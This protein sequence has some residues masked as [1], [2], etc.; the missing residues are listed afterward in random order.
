M[1]LGTEMTLS[2][3]SM[4][5]VFPREIFSWSTKKKSKNT[6]ICKNIISQVK[7]LTPVNS[8]I[9]EFKIYGSKKDKNLVLNKY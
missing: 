2:S 7:I 1:T 5:Q 8:R 3:S 6:M 4:I 9:G